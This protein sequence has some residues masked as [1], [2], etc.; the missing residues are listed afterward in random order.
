MYR[1]SVDP[2]GAGASGSIAL[3]VWMARGNCPRLITAAI[4]FFFVSP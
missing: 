2:S 4:D 3:V 1:C